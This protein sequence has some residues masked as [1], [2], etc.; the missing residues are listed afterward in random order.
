MPYSL[1]APPSCPL[2]DPP[3]MYKCII[4]AFKE[5]SSPPRHAPIC[6]HLLPNLRHCVKLGGT[7]LSIYLSQNWKRAKAD[8]VEACTC[9][10]ERKRERKREVCAILTFWLVMHFTCNLIVFCKS[11][12]K[13]TSATIQQHS[14]HGDNRWW[15][16]WNRMLAGR[17]CSPRLLSPAQ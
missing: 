6:I 13:S 15:G 14:R 12:S 11:C 9:S 17:G 5:I 1:N 3:Y 16:L 7:G 2:L 8:V 4:C 10:E